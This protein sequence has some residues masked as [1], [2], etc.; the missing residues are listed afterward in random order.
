MARGTSTAPSPPQAGGASGRWSRPFPRAPSQHAVAEH[1]ARIRRRRRSV[2]YPE[3]AGSRTLGR[4][5]R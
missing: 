3:L 4:N 5:L 1:S 2:N